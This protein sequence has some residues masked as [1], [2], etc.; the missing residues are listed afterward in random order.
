ML[1]KKASKKLGRPV[2]GCERKVMYT[3]SMRPSVMKCVEV[4]VAEGK[5]FSRSS[6]IEAIIVAHISGEK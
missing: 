5:F 6:A 3:I 2:S 1:K 4:L